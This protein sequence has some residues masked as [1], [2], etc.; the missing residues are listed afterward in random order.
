MVPRERCRRQPFSRQGRFEQSS[1]ESL[2]VLGLIPMSAF[3]S[4]C[5][6]PLDDDARFCSS[7]GVEVAS[8]VPRKRKR[9][10]RLAVGVLGGLVVVGAVSVGILAV[11]G[12]DPA[13]PVHHPKST[14]TTQQLSASQLVDALRKRQEQAAFWAANPLLASQARQY[15]AAHPELAGCFDPS[16][17]RPT[18]PCPGP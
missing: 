18:V 17:P 9:W 7:C 10:T 3:C 5:G 14:T 4:S 15:L 8:T 6:K 13:T 16:L 12:S 11:S 2:P 1:V